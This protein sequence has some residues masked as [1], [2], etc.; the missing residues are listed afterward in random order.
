M[1]KSARACGH[2]LEV[3]TMEDTTEPRR[4]RGWG[5]VDRALMLDPS[6]GLIAWRAAGDGLP[7]WLE[8]G[9]IAFSVA[10]PRWT[11]DG[12]ENVICA[13]PLRGVRFT[14]AAW[15]EREAALLGEVVAVYDPA[16]GKWR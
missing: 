16:R 14:T 3:M 10:M 4:G 15:L 9:E 11:L 13:D 12:G 7:R 8:A 2:G 5:M 1:H 6:R